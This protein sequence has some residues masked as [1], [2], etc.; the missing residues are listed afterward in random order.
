[1]KGIYLFIYL[2]I[3]CIGTASKEKCYK[4]KITGHISLFAFIFILLC[5]ILKH[6]SL[7]C[8]QYIFSHIVNL[9][10]FFVQL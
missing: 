7:E 10:Y 8:L 4:R 5:W 6:Y 9:Y 1:M 3:I 2:I